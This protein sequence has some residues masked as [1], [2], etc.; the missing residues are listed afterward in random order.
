MLP[1]VTVAG[2]HDRLGRH[3]PKKDPFRLPRVRDPVEVFR[4]QLVKA[5]L[6]RGDELYKCIVGRLRDGSVH[7]GAGARAR[8]AGKALAAA[9]DGV[10]GLED[11]DMDERY[12]KRRSTGAQ[13]LSKDTVLAGGNGGVVESAGVDSDLIPAADPGLRAVSELHLAAQQSAALLLGTVLRTPGVIDA[14]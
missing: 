13:L 14:A 4:K 1:A 10:N 2:K 9:V 5:R 11:R 3:L 12:R 8:T 6:L 7:R